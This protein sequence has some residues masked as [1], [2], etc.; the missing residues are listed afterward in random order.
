MSPMSAVTVVTAYYKTPS[1]ARKG[2]YENRV[3]RVT[4]DTDLTDN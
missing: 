4:R 3:T 1:R 2:V